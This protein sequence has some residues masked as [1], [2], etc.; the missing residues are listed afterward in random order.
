MKKILVYLKLGVVLLVFGAIWA[1][2]AKAQLY[3][4]PSKLAIFTSADHGDDSIG[5]D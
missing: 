5:S 3:N 4:N 1:K 2:I